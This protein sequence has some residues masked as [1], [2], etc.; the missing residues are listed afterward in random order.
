MSFWYQIVAHIENTME[1]SI[2]NLV[3]KIFVLESTA[4]NTLTCK[5]Y[6]LITA[7]NILREIASFSDTVT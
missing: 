4:A 5:L 3:P 7:Y 2:S 1:L 6:R